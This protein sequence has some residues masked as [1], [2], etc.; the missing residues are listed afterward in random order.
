MRARLLS[1]VMLLLALPAAAQDSA[2]GVAQCTADM[3]ALQRELA[4]RQAVEARS[5]EPAIELM[6]ALF[7]ARTTYAAAVLEAVEAHRRA[8]VRIFEDDVAPF[9]DLLGVHQEIAVEA[10]GAGVLLDKATADLVQAARRGGEG[11]GARMFGLPVA[12]MSFDPAE[13]ARINPIRAR[14][15]ANMLKL[16]AFA[17]DFPARA[18][19]QIREANQALAE[20]FTA[21]EAQESTWQRLLGELRRAYD[22]GDLAHCLGD[23]VVEDGDAGAT[24][25][26]GAAFTDLLGFAPPADNPRAI[27]FAALPGVAPPPALADVRRALAPLPDPPPALNLPEDL[28]FK[29]DGVRIL[30]DFTEARAVLEKAEADL[31]LAEAMEGTARFLQGMVKY[32]IELTARMASGAVQAVADPFIRNLSDSSQNIFAAMIRSVGEA[33]FEAVEGVAR[34]AANL[35]G[36]V[37]DFISPDG[38]LVTRGSAE[39]DQAARA[40]N[41]INAVLT[42]GSA[43][44][45]GAQELF[46]LPDSVKQAF[47][48]GDTPGPNATPAE[49]AAF[50]EASDRRR[51]QVADLRKVQQEKV[52]AVEVLE[53]R[54]FDALNVLTA[55]SGAKATVR[56]VQRIGRAIGD[57]VL[58]ARANLRLAEALDNIETLRNGPQTPEVAAAIEALR[59]DVAAFQTGFTPG[60]AATTLVDALR[61]EGATDATAALDDAG[62]RLVEDQRAAFADKQP[63]VQG[64]DPATKKPIVLKVGDTEIRVGQS[65]NE[66][67]VKSIHQSENPNL[68]IQQFKETGEGGL[69]REAAAG[70]LI[71]QA[72]I[73]S[74]RDV[75]F[76][77]KDGNILLDEK[78]EP[79]TVLFDENGNAFKQVERFD[80]SREV[81]NILESRP[82]GKLTPEEVAAIAESLDKATDA[83]IL[84]ID[85]KPSNIALVFDD[86]ARLEVNAFDRDGVVDL[87]KLLE[88]RRNDPEIAKSG[89]RPEVIDILGEEFDISTKDGRLKLQSLIVDGVDC[90]P[91]LKESGFGFGAT[92]LGFQALAQQVLPKGSEAFG[93]G[94]GT[95]QKVL[96]DGADGKPVRL[97][98]Q[99][100]EG[101]KAILDSA[102]DTR[103]LDTLG[104]AGN[105]DAKVVANADA[106]INATRQLNEQAANIA[107]IERQARLLQD[108]VRAGIVLNGADGVD[109]PSRRG[110]GRAKGGGPS[111]EPVEV[112]LFEIEPFPADE[113]LAQGEAEKLAEAADDVANAAEQDAEAGDGFPKGK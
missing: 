4:A 23:P 44:F 64:V 24:S 74:N 81:S 36:D 93:S 27:G 77:D 19:P 71:D 97:L 82:D 80:P 43:F 68:V 113:R 10:A 34:S 32:P 45:K 112:E 18:L 106:I 87:N 35:A 16:E 31:F 57:T 85:F 20:R 58:D 79:V 100:P 53:A 56:T 55:A 7:E 86:A 88:Q 37:L 5:C 49:I 22:G 54:A 90:C 67:G 1:I 111:D 104:D 21:L 47:G 89:G 63:F 42:I 84:L 12:A 29:R 13:V 33:G 62:A 107:A 103:L 61:A 72:G 60:T 109:E 48:G 76:R 110:G 46:V 99:T 98:D 70:D 38:L 83:G 50:V 17:R 39:A 28:A 92:D 40:N 105:V 78:G 51:E 11:G 2:G 73:R 6:T 3:A 69:K 65:F 9:R 95:F 25:I 52:K 15:D 8:R 96:P 26:G 91:A 66:G 108:S 59:A 30:K 75:P 101:A 102:R 94:A 41:S 14:H